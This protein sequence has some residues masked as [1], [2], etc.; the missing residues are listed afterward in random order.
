[1]DGHRENIEAEKTFS[2]RLPRGI[3]F[4]EK[5]SVLYLIRKNPLTTITLNPIWK[6]IL[7]FLSQ[8]DFIPFKEICNLMT[9]EPDK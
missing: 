2:Y 3:T 7:H 4:T 6:H 8:S 5:E 1:M 9:T